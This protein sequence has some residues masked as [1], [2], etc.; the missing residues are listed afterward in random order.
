VNDIL[1]ITE[2]LLQTG[3][4]VR[5][6]DLGRRITEIPLDT[7]HAIEQGQTPYPQP[8]QQHAWLGIVFRYSDDEQQQIWFIKL[9]LDE[10]GLLAPAARDDFLRRVIE[11]STVPA[12]KLPAEEDNPHG[13]TPREER[14]ASFHAR[15]ARL[16]GQAASHYYAP[17]RQY[18][19]GDL[20]YEQW[21]FVGLQGIADVAA[22]L[23]EDD[24]AA[25]LSGAIARLPATP[26]A[27]L[28]SCL[29]NECPDEQLA[30]ALAAR[31]GD[32][33]AAADAAMV[34]AI[35]RG[36]SNSGMRDQVVQSVLDTPLGSDVEVL[37]AIAG[38]AW[39]CLRQADIRRAFVENLARCPIGQHAFDSLLADV[40]FIPGLRQPLLD[41]LRDRDNSPQLSQTAEHFF[42]HLQHKP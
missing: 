1:T 20:G 29:E 24:N 18:F 15:I 9:P 2:F 42:Q 28:C 33:I 40:L 36:L 17:A 22:R 7:M 16:L 19:R 3:A 39:E 34:A 26:L 31:I 6:F 5:F 8:F 14:M 25:L 32:A 37:A 30:Q 23:D 12:D 21:N 41:I 27:A 4:Q 11:R 13:F 35:L 38:R 10:Q